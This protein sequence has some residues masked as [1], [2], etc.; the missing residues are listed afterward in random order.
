MTPPS[1][2]IK[3]VE[4]DMPPAPFTVEGLHWSSSTRNSRNR[5]IKSRNGLK[6]CGRTFGLKFAVIHLV[7]KSSSVLKTVHLVWYLH[8]KSPVA[9]PASSMSAH[10]HRQFEYRCKPNL[11]KTEYEK[12][13]SKLYWIF[14]SRWLQK[15]NKSSKLSD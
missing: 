14:F 12:G 11:I 8:T 5:L 2:L 9:H 6:I 15:W 7:T 1:G 4:L 3:S 10:S 13:R